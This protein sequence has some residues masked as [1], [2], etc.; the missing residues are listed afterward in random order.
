MDQYLAVLDGIQEKVVNYYNEQYSKAVEAEAARQA[1]AMAD[2]KKQAE[3]DLA[4]ATKAL[5][6]ATAQLE[7]N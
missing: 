5:A 1:Q 6:D 7:Y 3:V 2:A 4:T